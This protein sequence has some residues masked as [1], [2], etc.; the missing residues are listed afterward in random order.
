MVELRVQTF[1]F[2]HFL[3]F[4]CSVDWSPSDLLAGFW[5][6]R[7]LISSVRNI[8]NVRISLFGRKLD[9]RADLPSGATGIPYELFDNREIAPKFAKWCKE[10]AWC[11]VSVYRPIPCD[12]KNWWYWYCWR[13]WGECDG[14]TVCYCVFSLNFQK[15]L[16]NFLIGFWALIGLLFI[17]T[18][19]RSENLER[20]AYFLKVDTKYGTQFPEAQPEILG[21][22]REEKF[23]MV[24]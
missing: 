13:V 8:R 19:Q 18:N 3:S 2:R 15:Y 20:W 21:N 12:I 11:G 9:F 14:V 5:D 17:P 24:A 6:L 23:K 16:L 7:S 4:Y 10:F 22:S 1:N